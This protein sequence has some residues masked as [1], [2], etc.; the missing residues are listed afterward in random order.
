MLKRSFFWTCDEC[1][2]EIRREVFGLPNGWR[3]KQVPFEKMQHLCVGC[4][5]KYPERYLLDKEGKSQ[6]NK[7]EK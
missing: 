6:W 1:N 5:K 3:I 2:L 7:K 4:A